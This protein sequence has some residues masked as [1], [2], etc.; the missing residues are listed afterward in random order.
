MTNLWTGCCR[1]GQQAW[2]AG[3]S[4]RE[5]K[6][7]WFPNE[8][9]FSYPYDGY[10]VFAWWPCRQTSDLTVWPVS[11]TLGLARQTK[12]G[13]KVTVRKNNTHKNN[14]TK[15][16][17]NIWLPSMSQIGMCWSNMRL[18]P[19]RGY[20]WAMRHFGKG[21]HQGCGEVGPPSSNSRNRLARGR[22]DREEVC[23]SLSQWEFRAL[24]LVEIFTAIKLSANP[25]LG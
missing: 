20:L 18:E 22:R 25:E 23:L 19:R 2:T 6:E 21:T 5:E 10:S 24:W 9:V 15:P 16:T 4:A 8:I 7:D 14:N 13:Y 3:L 17:Q 12:S 11:P 1:Q